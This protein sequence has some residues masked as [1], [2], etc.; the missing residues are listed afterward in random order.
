MIL[1]FHSKDFR[2]SSGFGLGECFTAED[3]LQSF[4]SSGYEFVGYTKTDDLD[5]AYMLTNHIDSDWTENVDVSVGYGITPRSTSI[6]DILVTETEIH[7]V[8]RMGFEKL[9][10]LT[11]HQAVVAGRSARRAS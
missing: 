8:A 9:A 7:I 10:D 2:A 6:G 3:A 1:V 5:R 11:P 4:D